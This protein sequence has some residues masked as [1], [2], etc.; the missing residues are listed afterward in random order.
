MTYFVCK[1]GIV[2]NAAGHSLFLIPS[3]SLDSHTLGSS[4]TDLMGRVKLQRGDEYRAEE[5]E[6][7]G[8]ERDGRGGEEEGEKKKLALV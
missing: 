1:V 3:A 2:C 8:I 6:K 7:K 5:R 4:L